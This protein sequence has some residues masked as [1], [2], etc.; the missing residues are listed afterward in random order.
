MRDKYRELY[1]LLLKDNLKVRKCN[2]IELSYFPEGIS[3][4]EVVLETSP[5][6]DAFGYFLLGPIGTSHE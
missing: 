2:K 4:M 6:E 3:I 1:T 5:N